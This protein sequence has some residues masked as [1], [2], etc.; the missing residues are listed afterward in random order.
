MTIKTY[1]TNK[2]AQ[3]YNQHW[4]V[5][6]AKTHAATR[7]VIDFAQL[8]EIC[9]TREH[10]PRILDA[11]C[12]TGLLL[13]QFAHRIPYAELYGVDASEDM[14]AQARLVQGQAQFTQASLQ[15]GKRAGLPYEA[16]FFDLITCTNAL[17]NVKDPASVL[18]G[19]AE[20]L[21]PQ[22]QFVIEDF[23]RR[24]FP[25]PGR[26]F[27]W[28]TRKRDP[29]HVQAYTLVEAQQFCIKAG[30]HVLIAK[31]FTID[32]VWRGWVISAQEAKVHLPSLQKMEP[33][34]NDEQVIQEE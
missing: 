6:S 9:H 20:L 10:P 4:K 13:Q 33:P 30:L 32:T 5:F 19:L 29:Q 1:Y 11:A 12:G 27:E 16:G 26:I 25:F 22:G 14:L 23:A 28:F 3:S 2:R 21:A 24:T 15:A 7:S 34:L 17:H 31:N 18:H 8:E